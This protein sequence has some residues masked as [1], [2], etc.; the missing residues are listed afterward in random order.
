M[1]SFG[2][3]QNGWKGHADLPI[4]SQ[5][6]RRIGSSTDAFSICGMI[7]NMSSLAFVMR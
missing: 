6:D 3:Q 7:L 1:T 4:S 5:L 2:D